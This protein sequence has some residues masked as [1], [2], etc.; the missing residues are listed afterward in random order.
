MLKLQYRFWWPHVYREFQICSHGLHWLKI[1][2]KPD[3]CCS[4]PLQL[5]WTL[6]LLGWS[7]PGF[8]LSNFK[9]RYPESLSP[10]QSLDIHIWAPKQLEQTKRNRNEP[11]L[12]KL[13]WGI[14]A[15]TPSVSTRHR[16]QFP[17]SR[18]SFVPPWASLYSWLSSQWQIP[19]C[20]GTFWRDEQMRQR[21]A[22]NTQNEAQTGKPEPRR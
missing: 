14:H 10:P 15:K 5:L 19:R 21:G 3:K 4:L 22:G 16:I 1:K 8:S 2:F 9:S 11:I 12:H 6:L 13:Q 17:Q 20:L 18:P 7:Q